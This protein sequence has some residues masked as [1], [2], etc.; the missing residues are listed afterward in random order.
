M[1]SFVSFSVPSFGSFSIVATPSLTCAAQRRGKARSFSFFGQIP[2]GQTRRRERER[3]KCEERKIP[4][5]LSTYDATE[6]NDAAT[7][8][9]KA[10]GSIETNT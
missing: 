6:F 5:G 3:G 2:Q 1:F 10:Q 8:M 9:G 4:C 7:G